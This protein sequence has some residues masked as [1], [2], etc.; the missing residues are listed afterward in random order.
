VAVRSGNVAEPDDTWS[1]WSDEETDGEQATVKSPTARYLQYRVSLQADSHNETT[2][3]VR[4]V[5]VRYTNTNVAPEVTKVEVPD[6]NAVNL[7]NPRKVKI[8][9]SATDANEDEVTYSLLVRKET[10]TNWVVLEEELDKTDY[11]WDTTT[12]PFGVYQVKVVASDR[13]D[14]EEKSALTGERV[15]VPF[16]V[17]HTSPS[18]SIKVAGIDGD[19]VTLE[20]TAASPL[21]RLTSASFVINGKK[22]TSLFPADG[23]FDSKA[24]TF[25]FQ[26]ERLKPGT[27]VLVMRVRDAAGNTGSSDVVFTV[28][29]K[30]AVRR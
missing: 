6:L 24:R 23:L 14:N 2:P 29:P 5:S 13:K 25:H 16:V 10:W 8:K 1:D 26:T 19:K 3:S 28:Q 4:A 12:T 27:Y 17:C 20:A 30:A 9:W 15:G 22:S 21:V 18:I 7:D 11:E